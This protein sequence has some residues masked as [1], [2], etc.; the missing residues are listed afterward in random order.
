[1][2][3]YL[4]DNTKLEKVLQT[5]NTLLGH[6]IQR[7]CNQQIAV[8][9]HFKFYSMDFKSLSKS[10]LGVCA[11]MEREN[12]AYRL[13][14]GRKL[15]I[16]KCVKMGRKKQPKLTK[17]IKSEYYLRKFLVCP[18]C[19][20]AI[21]GATSRGGSGYTYSYYFCPTTGKHLRM[22]ADTVN[23]AFVDYVS[24]LRP[25][26]AIMQL[27]YEVL[28]DLRKE[29]ARDIRAVVDKLNCEMDDINKRMNKIE[30]K[31]L[32]GE[33]DNNAHNRMINRQKAQLK[34][35]EDRRELF[36]TP[37]RAHIEP[38]LKYSMSLIDNIDKFFKYAPADAKIRALSSIFPE[39]N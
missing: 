35:L 10:A 16:E 3:D 32:D 37:N 22:S 17:P 28:N 14:S 7:N 9:C 11:Q 34:K 8:Q 13:N 23:N 39:K 33:I 36:E 5:N 31:Y 30:D 26:E 19:G 27:Y 6:C 4:P 25:N 20:R 15:A 1:M 18:H 21:T 12:I 38:Q 24:G 2:P 29:N